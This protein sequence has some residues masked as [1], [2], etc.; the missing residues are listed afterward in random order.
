MHK[1]VRLM[2]REV[3]ASAL[4]V[5]RMGFG[6]L[7]LF[8]CINYGVFLCLECDYHDTAFL[9]K[10]AG[11][12]WV[13]AA[14]TVWLRAIWLAMAV[15]AVCVVVGLYYRL[16][17]VLFT[18]GFSYHFLL[19]EA[20]YLNHFYMVILFCVLMCFIPANRYW[21]L[22]AKLG[23]SGRTSPTTPLWSIFLLAAQLEIILIHAGLV[24][25]NWDWLNLEPM[26][27]WMTARSAD[28]NMLLQFLTLDWGIA[29]AAYS[30][31]ALHLLGAPL[32]LFKRTRLIVLCIYAA[33]HFTNAFV[34][35]IGIFPWFTLFASLLLFDPDWPK[36][37]FAWAKRHSAFL[38]N[39][40]DFAPLRYAPDFYRGTL[41]TKHF[42]LVLA[43]MAWLLFQSLFPLRHWFAPGNVAWNEDG[44][45]YSWRMKLRAKRG[46]AAFN[47]R[48]ESGHEW[49]VLPAASLNRKQTR[50][51]TCIPDMIWQFAHFVKTDFEAQGFKGISVT[52]DVKCSLNARQRARLVD[53]D[54]DLT[55]IP[56][57]EPVT[58]WILPL[59]VPLSNPVLPEFL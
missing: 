46:E 17:M 14:P 58:N 19:D 31:I 30:A 43:V 47:V 8:E 20:L 53:P 10:Y 6:A 29:V 2:F 27:L 25:I 41:S 34:F 52:A 48:D 44:H 57:N 23:I 40:F 59:K 22:D 11:F 28:E 42:V 36:Q 38:R 37:C 32:L 12:E 9:F 13:R 18:I 45:R 5:F 21:A 3:D 26:R 39:R 50:K 35:N 24:K 33:F 4:A 15:C 54:I 49:R 55:A 1:F 56:R 51:M 16:A 7:L